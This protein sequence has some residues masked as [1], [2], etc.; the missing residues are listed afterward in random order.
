[1][2]LAPAATPRAI[3]QQLNAEVSKMMAEPAFREKF[4]DAAGHELVAG[5]GE[6]L[7]AMLAADK[8]QFAAR[9]KPLN[10][11]LDD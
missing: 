6:K 7:M 9:V 5:N 10:L 3:V 2:L 1:M 4:I 8:V 11:K